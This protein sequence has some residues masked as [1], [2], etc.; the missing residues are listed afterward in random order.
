[1][2][3]PNWANVAVGLVAN[4]ILLVVVAFIWLHL[5]T[6]SDGARLEPGQIVWRP[7]GVVVTPLVAQ[8][9]GLQAGDVV[10]AVEGRSLESWALALFDPGDARSEWRIGQTVT[11]TVRRDGDVL[12]VPIT[13]QPYPLGAALAPFWS[14]VVFILATQF[15]ALFVF[16]RR[17]YD[18]A[19]RVL[20]LLGASLIHAIVWLLGLQ[21]SDLVGGV[22]FWL[23]ALMAFG[24]YILLWIAGLHFALVFPQ[25]SAIVVRWPVLIPLIY[26]AAY[27]FF[28]SYLAALWFVAP[29]TLAWLGGWLP[30]V[31]IIAI[32][33]IGLGGVAILRKYRTSRDVIARQQMRWA[34]FSFIVSGMMTV[35][36]WLIPY[37]IL[38]RPLISS[39]TLG[40]LGIPLPVGLAFAI[41]RYRLFDIEIIIRRTLVYGALTV[42]LLALYFGGVVLLQQV[43]RALTGQTSDLA[44]VASTLAIAALFNPLRRRIQDAIDRRFY[45]QKY[46]AAQTLAALGETMR[47]EVDL[48]RL[49]AHLVAAVEETLQPAHVSLWL[50]EQS[51]KRE[52]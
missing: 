41:L 32:A 40:L 47:D 30:G 26:V 1:M 2:K 38:G 45:R 21:V 20:F 15:I 35:V 43:F 12:D 9:G 8:P 17:P 50:R 22:G 25:P 23:Y 37:N 10:V 6:P 33:Y 5:L 13:L 28:F 24:G 44:I 27:G 48:D 14:L 42:M 51:V 36:L 4:A 34:V 16:L 52:T 39:A 29:T 31:G 46:D 3:R 19:A 11:Y 49:A 18:R 7:D